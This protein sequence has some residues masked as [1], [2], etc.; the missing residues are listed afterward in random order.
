MSRCFR[1]ASVDHIEIGGTEIVAVARSRSPASSC[2]VCGRMSRRVHSRYRR[3]LAYLPAHG[4]LE[5]RRF[6]C[7]DGCRR[8]IFAERFANEVVQPFGRRTSRLQNIIHHLGLA[9]AGRPG[10][11]LA[12]RLLLP[13][14]KDTLLRVV[15][16]RSPEE[17]ATPRIFGIDDWA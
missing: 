2:P 9:L 14:S 8:Q 4:N 7:S 10:Q 1:P 17:C 15:R 11:S 3:C 13:V 6:R 12:R 5:V 16:S